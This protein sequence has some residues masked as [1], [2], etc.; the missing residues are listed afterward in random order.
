MNYNK[1]DQLTKGACLVLISDYG[2]NNH[3]A[4]AALLNQNIFS[5]IS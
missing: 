3:F 4:T 5:I 1:Q 2:K